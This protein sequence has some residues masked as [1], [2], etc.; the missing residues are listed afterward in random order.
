MKYKKEY[1]EWVKRKTVKV[2]YAL[3]AILIVYGFIQAV[4][5]KKLK[6]KE[7]I[8]NS[9]SAKHNVNQ[10]VSGISIDND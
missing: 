1:N 10:K 2:C 4:S 7:L 6:H 5:V 8:E 3:L 9:V